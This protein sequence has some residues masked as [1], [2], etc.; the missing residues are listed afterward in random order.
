MSIYFD[1]FPILNNFKKYLINSFSKIVHGNRIGKALCVFFDEKCVRKQCVWDSGPMPQ[2]DSQSPTANQMQNDA[3]E[4][5][6]GGVEKREIP[7]HQPRAL[8]HFI[9]AGNTFS[10]RRR[11]I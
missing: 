2:M 10:L 7:Q 9:G 4:A 3:S 6:E 11:V 1:I 8:G 5:N